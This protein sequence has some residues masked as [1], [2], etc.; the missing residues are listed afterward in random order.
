[1]GNRPGPR[2]VAITTAATLAISGLTVAAPSAFA[3]VDDG[4][5]NAFTSNPD[6]KFAN[7][8][9]FFDFSKVA[10][11][12]QLEN[13]WD[14]KN[15]E[16]NEG[17]FGGKRIKEGDSYTYKDTDGLPKGME[18]TVTIKSIKAMYSDATSTDGTPLTVDNGG[19]WARNVTWN[20]FFRPIN[21]DALADRN[22]D[23]DKWFDRDVL[24]PSDPGAKWQISQYLDPTLFGNNADN[25]GNQGYTFDL[26]I[27]GT[28]NGKPISLDVI[29]S[30]GESTGIKVEDHNNPYGSNLAKGGVPENLGLATN[31]DGGWEVI[32]DLV[33]KEGRYYYVDNTPKVPTQVPEG[34]APYPQIDV[35]PGDEWSLKNGDKTY[36]WVDTELNEA[37][38]PW[39]NIPQS[40][41]LLV[42]RGAEKVS[43]TLDNN[44]RGKTGSRQG[45][46]AGIF[47]PTDQG[48]AP[49]SYG[50]ASHILD[51]W[52][53]TGQPKQ[54]PDVAFEAK[55]R[56]G[57]E[58]PTRDGG[59]NWSDDAKKDSE[60]DVQP[61]VFKDGFEQN[62]GKVTFPVTATNSDVV[63]WVDLDNNGKFDESERR[64]GVVEGGNVTFDW[65]NADK[66]PEPGK[67]YYAR[68]R[69]GGEGVKAD[70]M[71]QPTGVV[72]GGEVEDLKFT[73]EKKPEPLVSLGDKVWF[74][75]DSDGLQTDGEPGVKDVKVSLLD[76]QGNPVKQPGT[77]NPYVV[78]TGDNG[79]YLFENLPKGK[80]KVQ[81][82]YS[83]ARTPE[84]KMFTAFTVPGATPNG[85]TEKD[86]DVLD[87]KINSVGLTDVIDLQS[88]RR[89]VDA[90]LVVV[91]FELGVSVG[92]FVWHDKNNDGI[93]NDGDDSGIK[94][95]ELRILD[96]E[97]K[98]AKDIKGQEVPNTFTDEK[99]NYLFDHLPALED[100]QSYTVEVVKNPEGFVPAKSGATD[101]SEKDS[102]TNSAKTK[103]GALKEDKAKD[104]SLDF[105]FVKLGSLS[106][107]TWFDSNKDGIRD[108]N[109]KPR[110]GVTVTLLKDGKPVDGVDPVKTGED[111]TY[112]FENLVPGAGYSVRFGDTENLTKK[113]EGDV[114]KDKDSNAD[115]T[116]GETAAAEVKAGEN[117]PNLDAGYITPAVSVGDLVWHDKNNDGIQND[118]DDSGIPGV[119]LKILDPEGNPAKDIDGKLVANVVTDNNGKYLFENLPVLKDGQT[120]TV[121]VVKNPEGFVPAKS[122]A[123][124]EDKD[125]S[126]KSAQTAPGVLAKDGAQDLTLD[127]GFIKLGSLSGM[128]WFDADRDGIRDENEKP[129]AGVTVTLLKDGKPVEGVDPV[130]TGEDGTYKFENLVPGTGYSVRFGDT[131]NLTKKSSDTDVTKE[132]DS[133]ADLTTGETATAEVK[134][135][136]NT[137]NL[138]AGYIS[139]PETRSSVTVAR[140]GEP[141]KS[142]DNDSEKIGN[143]TDAG[144]TPAEMFPGID[145]T[146]PVEYKLVDA[147]GNP[148]DKVEVP[149]RGT[150]TIDSDGVVTFEPHPDF[151]G[152]ANTVMVTATQG[153]VTHVSQYTPIVI[154]KDGD[155]E[156][157]LPHFV[158]K[159]ETGEPVTVTPG[160]GNHPD[161]PADLLPETVKFVEEGQPKGAEISEDGKKMTVPGQGVWTI[162]ENGNFTFTPEA[163]FGGSPDTV[164][165]N[166][167]DEYGNSGT[168]D[169]TVTI[170]YPVPE[171]N[172]DLIRNL[173]IAGS[174]IGGIGLIA[175]LIGGSSE[176]SSNGSSNSPAPAPTPAPKPAEPKTEPKVEPTK[177]TP[178]AE[179]KKSPMLATTGA[180]VVGLLVAALVLVLAGVALVARRKNK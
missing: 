78:T 53:V 142:T 33:S 35:K 27:K 143:I 163:D 110:S 130:E 94:G 26:D 161:Y 122:G 13:K 9:F 67:D 112:K 12:E 25:V 45:V 36:G 15:P 153:E 39:A 56:V 2:I 7:E 95:V 114:T 82:D 28:L 1:M 23:R 133:N 58:M 156:F 88:D 159:G 51:N 111:G 37:G 76:E 170:V 5:T 46:V 145:P 79:E 93:Q 8:I 102:S 70:D 115:L 157:P 66:K 175:A 120:Y 38:G 168:N 64:V 77:E 50:E 139:E 19:I 85:N 160:K 59:Q 57:N 72:Q 165:Y 105:G 154:P 62:N 91:P 123:T 152:V 140:Q 158:D 178:K 169:G 21:F 138:D 55:N 60:E 119:E 14:S 43:V 147:S 101:D 89:D 54:N 96:P 34:K 80:Y 10:S 104:L 86:S 16:N 172:S 40:Q 42:S 69:V 150:Y 155:G 132:K 166:G 135:G 126:T 71:K 29:A 84:G 41:P 107:M 128:T 127:F 11:G 68:I 109:E 129:R 116:T 149:G 47:I 24:Y 131:E 176:G 146:L 48:D 49:E 162:D 151:V 3:A 4:T 100:G 83:A 90:G 52:N 173:I 141:Q 61:S 174:I 134:A 87:S 137:P 32:Q 171:G 98:P 167:E 106:G 125:S 18:V 65:S 22:S 164:K 63:A 17:G 136:E 117:T 148:T 6:A 75:K 180:S 124:D 179:A 44:P 74:D 177:V 73:V 81:F 30:D 144:I 92:D 99:G 20:D 118:G 113:T 103:P 121:E 31:A 97:G 108:D